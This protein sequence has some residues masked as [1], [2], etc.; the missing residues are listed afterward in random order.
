MKER[1]NMTKIVFWL[2]KDMKE[3][4]E[5]SECE[6]FWNESTHRI[7]RV[8]KDSTGKEYNRVT[9][10]PNS[11]VVKIEEYEEVKP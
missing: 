1:F 7:V 9:C 11:A 10:I 8:V 4:C 3:V 6:M 5:S 2:A